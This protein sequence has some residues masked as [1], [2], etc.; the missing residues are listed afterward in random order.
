[1]RP[2]RPSQEHSDAVARR[3]AE[4][5]AQLAAAREPTATGQPASEV[6][7]LAPAA[8]DEWWSDHTRVVPRVP[9]TVVPPVEVGAFDEAPSPEVPP[10][11]PGPAVAPA[12]PV[13]G[14]HAARRPPAW[15]PALVP[16]P[17]RGRVGLGSAQ[18]TAVAVLVAVGLA[19]TCWWVVRGDPEAPVP[20]ALEQPAGAPPGVPIAPLDDGTAA[21]PDPPAVAAPPGADP[22]SGA[23]PVTVDVAGRVRRPGIVVL[24]AGARVVD[25][26]ESAG[27]ARPGVDLTPIN[28]ARL[29]VDG[30]QIVVG[31]D[32]PV[33]LPGGA[34]GAPPAG[35]TTTAPALVDLNLADQALLETLPQV[36]PVTAAA[37]IAWRTE[38]GGFTAVTELLEV[39][40]IGDATLAEL[41]PHVTV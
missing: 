18:L 15:V 9:L 22:A 4:L 16:E 13:P 27:G 39:D 36:G 41:T 29:L 28:L 3:I 14:R 30:E 17:L 31:V 2:R 19:V 37:I 5:S 10:A 35:A 21:V 33:G 25:A 23:G 7:P 11:V 20:V 38:H 8:G 32:A 40:G 24:D 6:V 12:L 26:L 34:A 1:M